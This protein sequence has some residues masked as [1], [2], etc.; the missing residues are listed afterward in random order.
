MPA[1]TDALTPIQIAEALLT[2]VDGDDCIAW[3]GS[4]LSKPLYG[5][6]PQAVAELCRE[7]AVPPF[8]ASISKPD[9]NQLIN[10]AEECK[11]ANRAMYE[12]TLARVYGRQDNITRRAYQMLMKAPFK[13]YV[14]TNIDP[15]LSD[16]G[17]L[18]GLLHVHCYPDLL[19]PEIERCRKPL[20]Y[21]HGH[22]RPGGI[23]TG[24]NLVFARSEFDEAYGP[25]GAVRLFVQNLLAY[26]PIVFIGCKLSEPEIYQQFR[27]VHEMLT[28]I[29]DAT[30]VTS[31]PQRFLLAET[32]ISGGRR[33]DGAEEI[34]ERRLKELSVRVLRYDPIDREKHWEIEEALGRL[35]LMTSRVTVGAPGEAA[36]K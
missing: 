7:C 31:P 4:G 19:P 29:Q 5:D 28:R 35:C 12:A 9:A 1:T 36:P 11:T 2:A 17:A 13:A 8:D 27:L 22:A 26:Y 20:F 32:I 34:E 3:V 33:D 6:W 24:R 25:S 23:P 21:M 16:A 30:G 10:K 14:T 15:L 18:E